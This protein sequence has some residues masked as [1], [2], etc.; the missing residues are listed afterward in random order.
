MV[1]LIDSGS[2]HNFIDPRVAKISGIMVEQTPDLT[3]TVADASRLCSKGVCRA[4]VWQM[5]GKT[6][7]ADVRVLQIGGCDMVLG[8]LGGTVAIYPGANS[9]G[10]QELE[11]AIQLASKTFLVGGEYSMQGGAGV[12]KTNEQKPTTG[13]TRLLSTTF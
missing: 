12:S 8:G 4:F 10:L 3:V 6:F 2:T 13:A 11:D 1:I 9:V 7:T 5:Q